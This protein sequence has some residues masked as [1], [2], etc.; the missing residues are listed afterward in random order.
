MSDMSSCPSKPACLIIL[1]VDLGSYW[2]TAL[3]C[4]LSNSTKHVGMTFISTV[5]SFLA[6]M[7]GHLVSCVHLAFILALPSGCFYSQSETRFFRVAPKRALVTGLNSLWLKWDSFGP[8]LIVS[9]LHPWG[10]GNVKCHLTQLECLQPPGGNFL[11]HTWEGNGDPT[12][13]V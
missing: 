2:V 12:N 13:V 3:T 10:Q 7:R 8:V 4:G 11:N 1:P 5:M 9:D 6:S